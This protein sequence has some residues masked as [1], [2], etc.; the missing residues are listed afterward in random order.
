MTGKRVNSSSVS[1]VEISPLMLEAG[2]SVLEDLEGEVSR[3]F[4][5]R[6]IYQAMERAREAEVS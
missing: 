5:A 6:E 4:L 1:P 3:A 2:I